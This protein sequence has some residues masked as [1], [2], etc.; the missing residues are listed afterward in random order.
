MNLKINLESKKSGDRLLEILDLI[1]QNV[2]DLLVLL[3][4]ELLFHII[5]DLLLSLNKFLDNLLLEL[6]KLSLSRSTLSSST[7]ATSQLRML[8]DLRTKSWMNNL[9]LYLFRRS[10][11]ATSAL[12]VVLL[13]LLRPDGRRSAFATAHHHFD[14]LL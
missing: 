13:V 6:L 9:N 5:L 12:F 8:V 2:L 3:L 4:V 10:N 1:L 14:H 7:T 11:T